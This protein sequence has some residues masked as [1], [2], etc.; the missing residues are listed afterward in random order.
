MRIYLLTSFFLLTLTVYSQKCISGD[1]INGTGTFQYIDGTIFNG[2]WKNGER[3]GYGVKICTDGQRYE[4]Y[5]KD[6]KE[7]GYGKHIGADSSTYEGEWIKGKAEGYG[8]FK[9]TNMTGY[10]G[11][12]KGGYRNGEGIYFNNVYRDS[13]F[14]GIWKDGWIRL[15]DPVFPIDTAKGKWNSKGGRFTGI[16]EEHYSWKQLDTINGDLGLMIKYVGEF[17]NGIETGKG[18]GIFQSGEKYIGEFNRSMRH[19]LGACEYTDGSKYVGTWKHNFP[20][21]KGTL[22]LADGSTFVGT[23]KDGQWWTG[24]FTD[25]NGKKFTYKNGDEIAQ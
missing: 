17:K 8:V 11:Y 12:W 19:G 9:D 7:H 5:W 16:G 2:Q 4:G 25:K 23:F 10:I 3:N 20:N 22:Y 18:E 13:S 14:V 24:I 6:D 21:G 15:M 1:C